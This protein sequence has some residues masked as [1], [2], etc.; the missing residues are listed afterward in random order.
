MI[1]AEV[2]FDANQ[3]RGQWIAFRPESDEVVGFGPT[4]GAAVQAASEH[5]F[6]DAEFYCVPGSDAFFV[7]V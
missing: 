6:D 5:G 7:G 3:Y 4:L 1:K 2:A